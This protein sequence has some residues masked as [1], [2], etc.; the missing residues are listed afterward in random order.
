MK[1]IVVLSMISKLLESIK[2]QHRQMSNQIMTYPHDKVP[3]QTKHYCSQQ[4]SRVSEARHSLIQGRHTEAH[5]ENLTYTIL[6]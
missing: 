1:A 2:N 4:H 6:E 5:P 3:Q